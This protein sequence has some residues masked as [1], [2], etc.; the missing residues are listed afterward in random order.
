MTEENLVEDEK[1]QLENLGTDS[2]YKNEIIVI[3]CDK[4]KHV[5]IKLNML[6]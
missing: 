5:V 1:K 6:W 3:K 2:W 4:I